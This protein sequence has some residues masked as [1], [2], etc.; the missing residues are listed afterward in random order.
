MITNTTLAVWSPELYPTAIRGSGTEELEEG[1]EHEDERGG[2]AEHRER[3]GRQ[4]AQHAGAA[5]RATAP[6]PPRQQRRRA[7]RSQLPRIP[8]KAGAHAID[9]SVAGWWWFRVASSCDG[10]DVSV[11]EVD[12]LV[13]S[14]AEGDGESGEDVLP[15]D[16][17]AFDL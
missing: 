16:F 6:D 15:G 7:R 8:L 13:Q 11:V 12:R 2:P 14:A 10:C 9:H 1:A 4:A 5:D 3:D 17:A